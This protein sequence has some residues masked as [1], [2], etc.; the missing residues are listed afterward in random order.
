MHLSDF[1]LQQLD[2]ARLSALTVSQKEALL[3]KALEDLKEAR[4]RLKADSRPPS[5][6]APWL[7]VGE[8]SEAEGEP[9]SAEEAKFG[10][11]EAES[12][13]STEAEKAPRRGRSRRR[14]DPD[15][16]RVARATAAPS[17]WR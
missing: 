1:A 2:K 4:E 7:G 12:G 8:E 9:R 10:E 14:S 17:G 5:S 3:E 6:D 15:G 11:S 13:D 16:A